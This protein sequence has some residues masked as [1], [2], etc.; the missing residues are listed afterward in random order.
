MHK[1]LFST[2]SVCLI[3]I[4]VFYIPI[5]NI[6]AYS[7]IVPLCPETGNW[8]TL[9]RP[10]GGCD[11][12]IYALQAI[13]GMS[14]FIALKLFNSKQL[15]SYEILAAFSISSILLTSLSVYIGRYY[16]MEAFWF[17][18]PVLIMLLHQLYRSR[19]IYVERTRVQDAGEGSR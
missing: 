13:L 7:Y 9:L 3:A 11:F 18:S 16:F 17:L 8:S 6:Y 5:A 10:L 4:S 12:Y 15:S 1:V 19:R 14:L 2:F